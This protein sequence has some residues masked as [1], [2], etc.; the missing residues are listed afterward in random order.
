MAFTI[1]LALVANV[2]AGIFASAQTPV[3]VA[4]A[5]VTASGDNGYGYASSNSQGFYNITSLLNTGIYTVEASAIGFVDTSIR[6]VHV[7]AGSETPN[8]NILMPI[9][10]GI[11]GRVTDAVS[12]A[13]LQFVFVDAGNATGSG[14]TTI[15]DSNGNYQIITNLASGTYNVST[16]F[17]TGYQTKTISGVSV[18]AGVMTSNVNLA[19][20]KSAIITGTVTDSTT[21]AVLSGITVI[22]YTPGGS[23]VTSDT[24]NSSGKYTLDSDL[25]TG[26]YNITIFLPTNHLTKTTQIA[27]V[28]GNQYTVNVALDPSGI[29]S[30]RVTSTTGTPLFDAFVTVSGAG[31]SGFATTNE[32]GD[33]EITSG[34]GTG[35]YTV[36]ASYGG[37]SGF[38]T[39]VPVT[40]GVKTSNVN[41]QVML[42]P[43]GTITGRV[44]NATGAPMPDVS[45]TAEGLTGSGSATTN[46]TGYYVINAGLLTGTYNVTVSEYGYVDQTRTGVSVTIGQVTPDINF[47]LQAIASGRISGLVQTTGTPIPE[48]HTELTMLAIF[49]A[50]SIVIMIQ[51]LKDP[52]LKPAKPL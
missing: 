43:S 8:A 52:K 23:Y 32:T 13:P 1:S 5:F 35:T 38:A 12:G 50:A 30:G 40:A 14:Y 25:A 45:V 28:A 27:V 15:T 18:T 17:A 16:L 10:G 48:F 3:P 2:S 47:Q 37:G 4:G 19:L 31:G 44:T 33:Y 20:S 51:K 49:A 6:N 46:S 22:A 36:F 7:N 29:I 24:T 39:G 34:L 42:L 11:S 21:A 26:T 9:S 41:I